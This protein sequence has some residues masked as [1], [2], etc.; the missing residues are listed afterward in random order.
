V[1][2]AHPAARRLKLHGPGAIDGVTGSLVA[3]RAERPGAAAAQSGG[4]EPQPPGCH[5]EESLT[6]T[7]RGTL[8]RRRTCGFTGTFRGSSGPCGVPRALGL[9]SAGVST[10][11]TR[12]RMH[13]EDASTRHSGRCMRRRMNERNTL[14]RSAT[15]VLRSATPCGKT[16]CRSPVQ[17]YA[18]VI[19]TGHNHGMLH[20]A[21]NLATAGA[22]GIATLPSSA[23]TDG[24][25]RGQ[26]ARQK[27]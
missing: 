23:I 9:V 5:A 13:R 19:K 20:R 18:A 17:P 8:E 27:S 2:N 12:M 21:T 10:E 16:G 22:A 25:Q 3:V 6:N 14:L 15:A 4:S 11:I 7:A 24:D 26:S 1:Q